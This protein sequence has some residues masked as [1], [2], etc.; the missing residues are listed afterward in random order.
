M[1]LGAALL[2]WPWLGAARTAV[3]PEIVTCDLQVKSGRFQD[4]P[5]QRSSCRAMWTPLTSTSLELRESTA[6]C[7]QFGKSD[8]GID[9]LFS[10][11]FA[12]TV[13]LVN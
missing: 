1:A 12:P 9:L 4:P 3:I 10:L 8:G 2:P 5:A 7:S 13:V 11:C 6:I